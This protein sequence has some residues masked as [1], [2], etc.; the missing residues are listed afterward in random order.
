MKDDISLQVP[1]ESRGD[2][3]YVGTIFIGAPQSQP[4]RV[5]FDTGSEYLAVT[6]ALCDDSKA[7][8]YKFKV[9]DS[10]NNDF[11]KKDVPNRCS[12]VS[13]NM[14]QS[15][16]G[17]ILS[18][19]SSKLS[20]GSANLQ[21]FIW[22]DQACLQ[23]LGGNATSEQM[24]ED[25]CA[26]FEFLALYK[27]DGLEDNTDGILGL[28]PHKNEEKRKL[29]YLWAL[30]D[31]GIISRAM[32]SFSIAS[33]DMADGSYALFGGVNST[34]ILGGT[35]GLKSFPSFKNFLGTWALE[36]QK[37]FYDGKPMEGT[38]QSYPAIIDTGTS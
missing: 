21:G 34:Q 3:V 13:Y 16:T 1:L 22:E 38:E 17:K 20:Y 33:N 26:P 8:N 27:A 32:V 25:K 23:Q 36:G 14:H 29:H 37:V 10:A 5:V 11:I 24:K 6:S 19:S 7:G 30:K 28:S 12:T 15:N 2:A 4:A 35:G 18:R 31:N 9:Y